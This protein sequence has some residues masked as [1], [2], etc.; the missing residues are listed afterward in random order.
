[1]SQHCFP[2]THQGHPVQLML[3]WDRP[4]QGFFMVIE[5]TGVDDDEEEDPFVYSN[6]YDVDLLPTRGYA[7]DI[8]YF[9]AK[10]NDLG[11]QV[12]ERILQEVREDRAHNVGNRVVFYDGAGNPLDA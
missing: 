10:L 2:T 5:R 12:P 11:L 4:L 7:H 1:M 9:Q 3:G 8:S 6:L